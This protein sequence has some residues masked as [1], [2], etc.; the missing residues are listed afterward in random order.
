MKW[1]RSYLKNLETTVQC[2]KRRNKAFVYDPGHCEPYFAEN[3]YGY[4]GLFER[5]TEDFILIE[6][7]IALSLED[8][9]RF[10][11]LCQERPDHVQVAPYRHY[12]YRNNFRDYAWMHRSGPMNF[13]N[14]GDPFCFYFGFG[15][16]YLPLDVVKQYIKDANDYRTIVS[17]RGTEYKL[18]PGAPPIGATFD[19]LFSDWYATV[20]NMRPVP[21][22]WDVRPIHLNYDIKS[23]TEKLVETRG[24][25]GEG[26]RVVE[27]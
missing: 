10:E 13:V 26:V 1:Y 24:W 2:A 8:R 25:A 23:P 14:E 18:N 20:T 16:I 3:S 6:W 9:L 12:F 5:A 19:C 7:D 15:L 27:R 21:I 22:H 11:S 17:E 4:W